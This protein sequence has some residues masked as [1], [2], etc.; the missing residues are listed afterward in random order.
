MLMAT[1][2]PL[3]GAAEGHHPGLGGRPAGPGP[4]PCRRGQQVWP[5]EEPRA[6]RA[7]RRGEAQAAPAQSTSPGLQLRGG[8]GRG[9]LEEA[10]HSLGFAFPVT[11]AAAVY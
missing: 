10:A 4:H 8:V 6:G 3:Q 7:G 2:P 11:V 9:F 5:P 1:R